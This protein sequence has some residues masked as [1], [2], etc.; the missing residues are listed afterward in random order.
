MPGERSSES[1]RTTTLGELALT[2][3]TLS[4]VRYGA[5]VYTRGPAGPPVTAGVTPSGCTA[6]T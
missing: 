1:V 4:T 3:E 5:G 2:T 6:V